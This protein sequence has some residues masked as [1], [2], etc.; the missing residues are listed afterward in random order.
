[1][2]SV[3][4]APSFLRSNVSGILLPDHDADPERELQAEWDRTLQA[5]PVSSN[6]LLDGHSLG[7]KL[8]LKQGDDLEDVLPKKYELPCTGPRG[9]RSLQDGDSFARGVFCARL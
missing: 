7:V 9:P 3:A 1:M 6:S 8:A 2:R 4:P 5:Y